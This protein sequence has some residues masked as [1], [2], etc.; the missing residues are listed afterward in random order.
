M[1]R[2]KNEAAPKE[3]TMDVDQDSLAPAFKY[4]NIPSV[5]PT[6]I[7]KSHTAP[8]RNSIHATMEYMLCPTVSLISGAG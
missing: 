8:K 1:S 4:N 6:G 5:A 2:K 3:I 7:P